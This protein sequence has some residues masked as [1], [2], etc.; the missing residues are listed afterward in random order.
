MPRSE[1]NILDLSELPAHQR[2]EA[3]DFVEFLLTRRPGL[4][5]SARTRTLSAVFQTPIQVDEY[6]NVSRDDIYDEV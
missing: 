1:P 5:K 3:R 2:R 4:K 6:L